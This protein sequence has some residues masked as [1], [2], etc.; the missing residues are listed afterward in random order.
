MDIKTYISSGIIENYVLGLTSEEEEREVMRLQKEYP[1]VDEAIAAYERSLEKLAN[2]HAVQ[3]PVELK[4][5]VMDAIKEQSQPEIHSDKT[6]KII[7]RKLNIWKRI[8]VAAVIL[9]LISAGTNIFFIPKYKQYR[10]DYMLLV[11]N[12]ERIL[13][14]NNAL[15]THLQ[16]LKGNLQMLMNPDVKPVVMQGVNNHP[17]LAATVY[18]NKKDHQTYLGKM[19]LP[20]PPSGKTYQL[21]AIINGKPVSL[22]IYNPKKHKDNVPKSMKAITKGEVQAFAITLEKAGGSSTPTMDQMYVM[23][24]VS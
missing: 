2:L 12:K 13:A 22:G 23:G 10:E 9:F 4:T 21:W 20:A 3:P 15:N 24:A 11:A 19:N 14:K 17:G 6:T 7:V 8:A 16:K 5:K 18:W 1:E